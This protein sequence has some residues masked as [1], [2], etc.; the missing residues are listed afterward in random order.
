MR[1]VNV[2]PNRRSA[3]LL[4]HSAAAG[5]PG[6]LPVRLCRPACGQ[7]LGQGAAHAG[8]DGG[9]DAWTGRSIPIR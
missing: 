7:R 5:G 9:G 6:R 3:T 4:G 2:R 1:W 8:G